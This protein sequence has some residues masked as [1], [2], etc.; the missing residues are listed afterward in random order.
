[1]S[2]KCRTCGATFDDFQDVL[3][4]ADPSHGPF[5]NLESLSGG[6]DE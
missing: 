3:E 5:V 1:M 4:N 2:E 6:G